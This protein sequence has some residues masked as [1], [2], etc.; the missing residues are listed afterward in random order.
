MVKT[1]AEEI[2]TII[3]SEANNNP[4]PM[5]C[6]VVKRYDNDYHCDVELRSGERLTYIKCTS[7]PVLNSTAVIVFIDGDNDKPIAITNPSS[8]GGFD[9]DDYE[10]DFTYSWGQPLLNEDSI[11][12]NPILKRKE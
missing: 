7:K 9:V 12:I 6:T 11:T 2:I 3:N 10:V 4:P 1:L 8:S 5:E